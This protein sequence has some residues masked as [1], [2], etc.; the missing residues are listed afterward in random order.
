MLNLRVIPPRALLRLRTPLPPTVFRKQPRLR[1]RTQALGYGR[2][3]RRHVSTSSLTNPTVTC[4]PSQPPPKSWVE[5]APKRIR[6]YLYLA[7][8][9]KPIGTLLLYYPCSTSSSPER[10]L[11]IVTERIGGSLVDN[12][13]FVRAQSPGNHSFSV[14]D[15]LRGRRVRYARSGVYDQ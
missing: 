2:A 3:E 13:G 12:Y 5:R 7:R 6:P 1:L 14:P 11:R 10:N 15:P 4:A 9:D 8:V